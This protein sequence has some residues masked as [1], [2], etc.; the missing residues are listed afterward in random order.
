MS[1]ASQLRTDIYSL[2]QNGYARES[3]WPPPPTYLKKNRDD[4]DLMLYPPSNAH[5]THIQKLHVLQLVE[6]EVAL[7]GIDLQ[8]HNVSIASVLN[9]FVDISKRGASWMMACQDLQVPKQPKEYQS[10]ARMNKYAKVQIDNIKVFVQMR[11]IGSRDMWMFSTPMV[12]AGAQMLQGALWHPQIAFVNMLFTAKKQFQVYNVPFITHAAA[13]HFMFKTLIDDVKGV[14][15]IMIDVLDGLQAPRISWPR[16]WQQWFHLQGFNTIMENEQLQDINVA[17]AWARNSA[18][19]ADMTINNMPLSSQ[20]MQ[21]IWTCTC[22]VPPYALPMMPTFPQQPCDNDN[23]TRDVC[24]SMTPHSCIDAVVVKM[25]C[26]DLLPKLQKDPEKETTVQVE[27]NDQSNVESNVE[28]NVETILEPAQHEPHIQNHSVDS[29]EHA[30]H[31]NLLNLEGTLF[32]SLDHDIPFMLKQRLSDFATKHDLSSTTATIVNVP[33]ST[34][35][36]GLTAQI[37]SQHYLEATGH[38]RQTTPVE[39]DPVPFDL[40]CLLPPLPISAFYKQSVHVQSE[41]CQ[42]PQCEQSCGTDVSGTDVSGTDVPDATLTTDVAHTLS[43]APQD[44]T[45]METTM[46]TPMATLIETSLSPLEQLR[47]TVSHEILLAHKHNAAVS[48][49]CSDNDDTIFLAACNYLAGGS[50][51]HNPVNT[52]MQQS[53]RCSFFNHKFVLDLFAH[54]QSKKRKADVETNVLCSEMSKCV[55]MS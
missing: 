5:M 29:A 51:I 43:M 13:H 39:F 46:E 4:G 33:I 45:T 23:I 3:Y 16:V 18:V 48:N 47:Q 9:A 26:L 17:S 52:V 31:D 15:K 28:P 40:S 21:F 14:K 30:F 42:Q 50:G 24:Q 10:V 19:M 37:I 2:A 41:T 20:D 55:K 11:Q 27:S 53:L 34:L 8:L 54:L 12:L 7:L 32:D 38:Y 44:E 22:H 49:F 36:N 35:S 1:L 6:T 25:H